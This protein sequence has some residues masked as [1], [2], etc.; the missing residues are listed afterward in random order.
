[1]ATGTRNI[2]APPPPPPP[3]SGL[4]GRDDPYNRLIQKKLDTTRKHLKIIDL[5]SGLMGLIAFGLATLLVLAVID[6][7]ILPLNFWGR[8]AGLALL[9]SGCSYFFVT[10]IA[11]PL[12]QRINPLFA[13]R[14]IEEA[15]P[16]LK[17]SLINFLL[18]RTNR[19]AVRQPVFVA[20]E[21]QAADQLSDIQV[22]SMVDRSRVI[23]IGCIL[24]G[25]LFLCG[26]YKI[27]STKD[28]V[29]T[30]H[31][32]LAPWAQIDPS[33]RVAIIEV[34]PG[35]TRIYQG[36][37]LTVTA[38]VNQ[39]GSDEPVDLFFT[40][41]DGQQLDRLVG[42]RPSEDG[43]RYVCSLPPEEEG[44]IGVQQDFV[45]RVEAG[46]A[47]SQ[48]YQVEVVPAPSIVVQEVRCN[49]PKYTG[50]EPTVEKMQGDIRALEG[51]RVTVVARANL[52]IKSA[53]IEFDPDRRDDGDDD[54][55][56]SWSPTSLKRKPMKS[57]GKDARVA[58]TLKLQPDRRTAEHTSYQL[59]FRTL[60]GDR[61][62][63]PVQHRI[64]VLPDLPPEVE[65]LKP[66]RR[67]VEVPQDGKLTIEVRANDADYGLSR[68][69]LRCVSG[70]QDLIASDLMTKPAGVPGQV[71]ERYEFQPAA[72]RLSAGE[73]AI[74]W[75]VA[76]DN[77]RAPQTG[78]PAGNVSRTPNYQIRITPPENA[79]REAET[80]PDQEGEARD[81]TQE[82]SEPDGG[83]DERE[84]TSDSRPDDTS[85]SDTGEE[86]PDGQADQPDSAAGED[87]NP[88]Q[89]GQT[90][91]GQTSEGQPSEGQPSEGQP[92][93]GEPSEGEPSEG[94]PGGEQTSEG[95]T[96]E[97]EGET[98]GDPSG[99][100]SGSE[101][102]QPGSDQAGQPDGSGQ[103]GTE[104]GKP[105]DGEPGEGQQES[106]DGQAGEPSPGEGASDGNDFQQ[107][108]LDHTGSEDGD[109]FEQINRH[110]RQ[111]EGSS[112]EGS[113][114]AQEQSDPTV[115]GEGS[116]PTDPGQTTPE[117]GAGTSDQPESGDTDQGEQPDGSPQ[118]N[119]VPKPGDQQ[120]E[121]SQREGQPAD[122]PGG[123]P[124]GGD[125]PQTQESPESG[126]GQDQ[127]PGMGDN[128]ESGAGNKPSDDQGAPESQGDQRQRTG[129]QPP[130]GDQNSDP[131][132]NDGKSPANSSKPSESEGGEGGD[133]KGGGDQGGGQGSKQPGNDSAGS[134][135]GADQGSGADSEPG[136]GQVGE[137][138]GSGQP[139]ERPTGQAGDE[140]GAG[141]TSRPDAS[142]RSPGDASSDVP[143]SES[144][145]DGAT[146][147]DGTG[148]QPGTS[149]DPQRGTPDGSRGR[150]PG[151]DG[152]QQGV[153]ADVPPAGEGSAADA[154]NLEHARKATD[155]ALE[156][157]EHMTDEQVRDALGW[158]G[159]QKRD[160]LQRWRQEFRD[161]ERSEA[162]RR[163]LDESLQSLGLRPSADRLERGAGRA[164]QPGG[165]QDTSRIAPPAEFRELFDAFKRGTARAGADQLNE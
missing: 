66:I 56:G 90:S 37:V 80:N 115:R 44:E 42:M 162:S 85:A 148:Q 93:E 89:D 113:G 130:G 98:A 18:L 88:S 39:L 12:I 92:S 116:R 145:Q 144:P 100:Q 63:Q 55:D 64:Q 103:D 67:E 79:P 77:R 83:T 161:A 75:A 31:R 38:R 159:D 13:A 53:D 108:P 143:S 154:A 45:Y 110:R 27:L 46:D 158:S 54:D 124:E 62:D 28:P 106:G 140:T 59:R 133:R 30:V 57:S 68:I 87:G 156:H 32:I 123:Q 7:W 114:N 118:D 147:E 164:D 60:G 111:Q 76:E 70:G 6:H 149:S 107:R 29:Q 4:A 160:F 132:P 14:A 102:G 71:I 34:Q 9:L 135:S 138:A 50:R 17:N 86:D 73:T 91:E 137:R 157:L 1:M 5:V 82:T 134:S 142:G 48:A 58:F 24:T 99:S 49:Y 78:A 51:T 10:F 150:V 121:G 22:E 61:N 26:I 81:K 109:A 3:P 163:E 2:P 128:S 19:G 84:E 152:S 11:V 146:G 129:D 8:L 141:S 25:V 74:V 122:N 126:Q 104:G 21:R 23:V 139:S 136:D 119:S 153:G 69:G 41:A 101:G 20:V 47:K 151:G 52:E 95:Q 131:N 125:V 155:L 65:I 40:T 35:S 127:R 117:S 96:G 43:L 15:R 120:G 105:S 33:T 94:E 112:S 72:L 16:S 97:G 36:R 165:V